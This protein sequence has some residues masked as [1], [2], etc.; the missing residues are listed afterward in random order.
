MNFRLSQ[1]VMDGF[2]Q[3]LEREKPVSFGPWKVKL[4]VTLDG[5]KFIL[6]DNSWVGFR[7]SGTEP[8]VRLYIESNEQKKMVKLAQEGKRFILG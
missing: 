1:E 7:L 8:I 3:R 4:V 2:K 5:Y 6:E